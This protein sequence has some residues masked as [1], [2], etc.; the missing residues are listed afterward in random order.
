MPIPVFTNRFNRTVYLCRCFH[1]HRTHFS[2]QPVLNYHGLNKIKILFSR[3][4]R[5]RSHFK[6]RAPDGE[7]VSIDQHSFEKRT[8]M[9]W[10]RDGP[11]NLQVS[12]GALEKNQ[13]YLRGWRSTSCPNIGPG[14]YQEPSEHHLRLLTERISTDAAEVEKH[15][16]TKNVSTKH[17][18]SKNG[19]ELY[20]T[21]KSVTADDLF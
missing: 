11:R 13:I 16:F 18:D 7:L 20:Q 6:R 9:V 21:F 15:L 3:F 14:V 12:R 19:R 5:D 4:Q 10:W 2:I 17:V 8:Q 1:L